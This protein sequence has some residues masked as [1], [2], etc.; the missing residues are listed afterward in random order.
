MVLNFIVF[1]SDIYNF[2]LAKLY[3]VGF[4]SYFGNLLED[5]ITKQ[6]DGNRD[7]VSSKFTL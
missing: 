7:V 6:R 1:V 2:K 4:N 3:T 5:F